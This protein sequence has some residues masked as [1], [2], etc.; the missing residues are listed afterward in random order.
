MAPAIAIEA[1]INNVVIFFMVLC[2]G[3]LT[4]AIYSIPDGLPPPAASIRYRL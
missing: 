3:R 1:T 2:F 4:E